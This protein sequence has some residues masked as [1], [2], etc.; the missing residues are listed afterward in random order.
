MAFLVMISPPTGPTLYAT[1]NV[2]ASDMIEVDDRVLRNERLP[3][4]VGDHRRVRNNR[5]DGRIGASRSGLALLG[6]SDGGGNGDSISYES[7]LALIN[8]KPTS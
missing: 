2:L 4:D 6:G 7:E 1:W 3:H 5:G 8:D